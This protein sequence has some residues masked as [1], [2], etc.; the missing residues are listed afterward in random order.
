MFAAYYYKDYRKESDETNDAQP[1]VL[2]DE[3]IHTQ[4][5]ILQNISL[6]PQ[7]TSLMNTKEKMKCRKV[8]AV[9][10]YHTPNKTKE[11]ERYFP[12][13]KWLLE[14]LGIFTVN[15]DWE[16]QGIPNHNNSGSKNLEIPRNSQKFPEIPSL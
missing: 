12:L 10:R 4:H 9:I 15:S 3:V 11:P 14:F 13:V 16:F 5:S 6:P 2:T 7:I 8:K 1:N